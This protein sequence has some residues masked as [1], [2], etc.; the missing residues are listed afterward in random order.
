MCEAFQPFADIVLASRA[1][2]RQDNGLR[3]LHIVVASVGPVPTAQSMKMPTW[4]AISTASR[5]WVRKM[6]CSHNLH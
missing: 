3:H 6:R 5:R 4:H 1:G 2:R